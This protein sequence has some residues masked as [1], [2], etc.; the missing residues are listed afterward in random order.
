M[1]VLIG[2]TKETSKHLNHTL[3]RIAIKD[4]QASKCL[5]QHRHYM[6]A[7][8]YF[9]QSV[10]KA[11]KSFGLT[12]DT[13]KE[14]KLQNQ[15][16]HKPIKIFERLLT[17]TDEQVAKAK[18][19]LQKDSSVME[20]F[21]NDFNRYEQI[22]KK[23]QG[24]FNEL[25]S[26]DSKQNRKI[27]RAQRKKTRR[28]IR[29]W[30]HNVEEIDE[31]VRMLMHNKT[32]R[33]EVTM[34]F[35]ERHYRELKLIFD[36][37][38]PSDN[39]K[40]DKE[41]LNSNLRKSAKQLSKIVSPRFNIELVYVMN[42]L[43]FSSIIT[44]DLAIRSRYP[45]DRFNPLKE[46][47]KKLWTLKVLFPILKKTYGKLSWITSYLEKKQ[48]SSHSTVEATTQTNQSQIQPQQGIDSAANQLTSV[49]RRAS[50]EAGSQL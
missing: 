40:I 22:R 30:I 37:I 10:E 34:D 9:Q 36:K 39:K 1:I 49:A 18:E 5:Y 29:E 41:S 21:Q 14:D 13:I 16:G 15:I 23:Q 35:E 33:R 46:Y 11:L 48:K 20:R 19:D 4:L 44:Y 38:I 8:F 17:R 6:Q 28:I 45:V 31:N 26:N 47:N 2:M 32:F 12:L 50:P 7:V 25:F 27:T 42:V 24:F 3:L 43:Q